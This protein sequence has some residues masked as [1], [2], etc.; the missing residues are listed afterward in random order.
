MPSL[1]IPLVISA[2]IN[3]TCGIPEAQVVDFW[4]AAEYL[5]KAAA[6]IYRGQPET[7]QGWMDE[8]CHPLKHDWLMCGDRCGPGHPAVPTGTRVND[9]QPEAFARATPD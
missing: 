6:V 7:R 5:G 1:A 8:N 2:Y 4:H 9:S 3:L